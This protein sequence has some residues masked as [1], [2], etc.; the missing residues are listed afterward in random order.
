MKTVTMTIY[1]EGDGWEIIH[2]HIRECPI[3]KR[4]NVPTKQYYNVNEDGD[5]I[6]ID[7][8]KC[9]SKFKLIEGCFLFKLNKWEVLK[10]GNI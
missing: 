5:D 3:C 8:E 4:K 2:N 9:G 6:I 7:C 10:H 1:G